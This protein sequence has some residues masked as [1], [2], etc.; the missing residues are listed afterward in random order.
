M[1]R[2]IILAS[3]SANRRTA[4]DALNVL[5]KSIPPEIDEKSISDKD[6]TRRTEK[7][8]RIK[9]EKILQKY[10]DAIIIAGDSYAVNNGKA[11]EKPASIEE[12]KEMLR[13]ESGGSGKFYAGFCYIDKQNK[14]DFSTTVVVD[15]SLRIFS[16]KE[17]EKFVEKYPVLTWSGALSPANQYGITMIKSIKG[18]I[19]AFIYGIPT[20]LVIENLQKSGIEIQ[21]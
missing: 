20:E 10:P 12:A 9:A 7:I 15:F 3:G 16:E 5:Y 21:P 1:N 13:Q 17:V 14:I 8:A 4:M 18:S 19:N 6:H 2:K 11:F